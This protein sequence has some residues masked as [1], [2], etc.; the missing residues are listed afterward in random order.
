[1]YYQIHGFVSLI[2]RSSYANKLNC[3][4]FGLIPSMYNVRTDLY[5]Q[6]QRYL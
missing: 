4:A 2:N 6:H 3:V 1:M 5:L